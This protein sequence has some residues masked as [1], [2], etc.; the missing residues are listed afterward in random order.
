MYWQSIVDLK[1][2]V[3]LESGVLLVVF[4]VGQAVSLLLSGPIYPPSIAGRDSFFHDA[5]SS[6]LST[7]TQTE[8]PDLIFAV[9]SSFC[10]LPLSST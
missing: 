10:L 5:S 4:E 6:R 1:M 3:H 7:D 9:G 2:L 8:G